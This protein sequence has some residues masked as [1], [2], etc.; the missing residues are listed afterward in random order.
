[1]EVASAVVPTFDSLDEMWLDTAKN[2]IEV[3][4]EIPSRDGP[5]KEILGFVAR[6]RHPNAHFMFNP[7]RKMSPSYAGAELLWILSGDDDIEMIQH[8]APQYKR[9][10]AGS[11]DDGV[12]AYGAYG[13]RW[14]DGNQLIHLIQL[15]QEK[16]DTRQ[17]IL[18][19]YNSEDLHHALLGDKNDIPCTAALMFLIRDGE[20]NLSAHMRSN[21]VWLGLPY[22]VFFFTSLQILLAQILGLKLGWYQHSA[23]SMHLYDRNR[24]KAEVAAYPK[25]FATGGMEY[26]PIQHAQALN[27]ILKMSIQLEKHNRETKCCADAVEP[28]QST[29]LGQAVVWASFKWWQQKTNLRRVN[30]PLMKKHVE[31]LYY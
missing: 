23:M 24:E 31:R 17:A 14:K 12:H 11:G 1:M 19:M 22:D 29:L 25:E 20:L 16:P 13:A 27:D 3:G 8:Y 28:L 4:H 15:L 9:F 10:V 30:S 7:H 2:L 26:R 21:D 6:L 5:T 18:T